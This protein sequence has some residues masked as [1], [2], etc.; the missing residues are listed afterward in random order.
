M[1]GKAAKKRRSAKT[2][3]HHHHAAESRT[4]SAP[5]QKKLPVTVLSGF[6]GSGKTTLLKNILEQSGGLRIAMVVNDMGE[7]NVDARL[8]KSKKKGEGRTQDIVVELTNG[9]ICCTLRDDLV[10]QI[11]EF[12]RSGKY[13][14]IV[15]ESTGIGEPLAVAVGFAGSVTQEGEETQLTDLAKLDTMVTVVDG[16]NFDRYISTKKRAGEVFETTGTTEEVP[17]GETGVADLL[18]QQVEFA[19]VI[20]VNK[21]DLLKEEELQR[22][23]ATCKKLNS[24]AEVI[25]SQHGKVPLEKVVGTGKFDFEKATET[26]AWKEELIKVHVPETEE[27]GISSFRW[28]AHRPFHPG[29]LHRLLTSETLATK[30]RIVRLKGFVWLHSTVGHSYQGLLQCAGPLWSLQADEP[31]LASLSKRELRKQ[32]AESEVSFDFV[33]RTYVH[34]DDPRIGDRHQEIV[35]IGQAVEKRAVEKQLE[36]CLVTDAEW[37]K[38]PTADDPFA[39]GDGECEEDEEDEEMEEMEEEEC[40]EEMEEDDAEKTQLLH[41]QGCLTASPQAAKRAPQ[42]IAPS[43]K[44]QR[45]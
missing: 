38:E 1:A 6:L 5:A 40:P 31:W 13:D 10:K 37:G 43:A 16:A 30:N 12:S 11:A 4:A 35:V 8:V 36:S 39:V 9:C 28:I 15:I 17:E 23:V 27:Y 44:R 21:T 45:R 2:A 19:D 29:R 33:K 7:V 3:G 20:V 22:V 24:Q 18:V 34:W 25:T 26:P 41:G 32:L 42:P 14:Y